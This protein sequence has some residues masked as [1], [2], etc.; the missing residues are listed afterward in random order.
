[1]LK[2]KKINFLTRSICDKI[3]KK[4]SEMKRLKLFES[5]LSNE[6]A[7]KD[8]AVVLKKMEMPFER[9]DANIHSHITPPCVEIVFKTDPF[10]EEKDEYDFLNNYNENFSDRIEFVDVSKIGDNKY[11]FYITKIA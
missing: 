10:S 2:N 7:E 3:Y 1:M 4:T 11:R 8:L 9:I 5:F 6:E